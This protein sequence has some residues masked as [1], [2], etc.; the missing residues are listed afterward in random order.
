MEILHNTKG[1][2]IQILDKTDFMITNITRIDNSR[3]HTN[4]FV[5]G[6]L[7]TSDSLIP[8]SE[9]SSEIK[10]SI[11]PM[12]VGVDSNDYLNRC[13]LN[14]FKSYLINKLKFTNSSLAS[15]IFSHFYCQGS[16]EEIKQIYDNSFISIGKIY[17]RIPTKRDTPEFQE[18]I[19]HCDP[20][21]MWSLG[22][23]SIPDG[24]I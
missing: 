5:F 4:L 8:I 7:G 16:F 22:I 21:V 2:I 10:G 3:D 15:L 24:N 9:I 17:F 1:S 23:N 20:Y 6:E 14:G 11:G 12:T 18:F 13:F 19:Y